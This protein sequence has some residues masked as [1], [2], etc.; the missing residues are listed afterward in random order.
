M[1]TDS[2]MFWDSLTS[3]VTTISSIFVAAGVCIG[4]YQANRGAKNERY[5]EYIARYEEIITHLPY[6][7]FEKIAMDSA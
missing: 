7:I 5:T 3:V 6:G 4:F 2:H 1:I